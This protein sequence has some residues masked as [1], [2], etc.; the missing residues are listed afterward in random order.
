MKKPFVFAAMAWG[1]A[2]AGCGAKPAQEP[3]NNENTQP[4]ADASVIVDAGTSNDAGQTN[5]GED[6]GTDAGHPMSDGGFGTWDGGSI[7][8]PLHVCG[9]VTY[10]GTATGSK[11]TIV[12]HDAD[13]PNGPPLAVRAF[14]NPTFPLGFSID[15]PFSATYYFRAW[16][17]TNPN[18]GSL[19]R[20]LDPFNDEA[21]SEV[22]A[23]GVAEPIDVPLSDPGI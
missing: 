19:N 11:V 8:D 9:F 14:S 3:S 23:N 2:M 10:A 20:T 22:P 13:P 21:S 6:A 18:D 4:Q 7:C 15:V 1:L 12:L 17:D 5:P 16:L